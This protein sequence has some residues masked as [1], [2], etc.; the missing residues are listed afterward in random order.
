MI[1]SVRPTAAINCRMVEA[2]IV[3][4]LVK[5][6]RHRNYRLEKL[7]IEQTCACRAIS[8]TALDSSADRCA[9]ASR[10]QQQYPVCEQARVHTGSNVLIGPTDPSREVG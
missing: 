7:G 1:C 6:S 3:T 2:D 4:K 9:G 10:G 5:D 8:N